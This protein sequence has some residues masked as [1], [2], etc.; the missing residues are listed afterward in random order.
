MM[1][2]EKQSADRKYAGYY[3]V[4]PD[5][6]DCVN[7][8]KIAD[9]FVKNWGDGVKWT[10]RSDGGPHEASF[11]R[12]DC[13]KLKG[14]FGWNPTWHIGKAI[15]ETVA[16]S[17]VYAEGGDIEAETEKEIEEFEADVR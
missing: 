12:L 15:E 2:A 10:D 13:T 16:W 6:C 5:L 3:N 4:G 9:M 11:L 1:I 7:A 8:G 17:R 14:T